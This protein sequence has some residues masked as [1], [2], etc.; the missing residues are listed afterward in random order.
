[1]SYVDGVCQLDI[2]DSRPL[3]S[4]GGTSLWG[5]EVEKAR[6]KWLALTFFESFLSF[7]VIS[8]FVSW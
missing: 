1:M 3:H 7:V 5:C 4:G 6:P 2:V 8:L